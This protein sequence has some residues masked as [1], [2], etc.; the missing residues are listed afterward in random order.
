MMSVNVKFEDGENLPVS[1]WNKMLSTVRDKAAT[2]KKAVEISQDGV[3][4]SVKGLEA[5][6]SKDKK[7]AEHENFTNGSHK[8]WTIRVWRKQKEAVY[9]CNYFKG[10]DVRYL[11][12]SFDSV[13]DE[14]G[15]FKYASSII[16]DL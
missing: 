5:I 13:V 8:G 6:A 11:E 16:D 9:G 4:I 7:K 10:E 15:V 14:N 2:G 3:K 12:M 1:N